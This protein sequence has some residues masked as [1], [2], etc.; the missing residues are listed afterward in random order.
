MTD[1]PDNEQLLLWWRQT[2]AGDTMAFECIHR[3]LFAALYN[4]ARKLLD[5]DALARDALQDLFIKIWTKRQAIGQLE[6]VKSYFF[7]A[8][9]RQVWNQQRNTRLRQMKINMLE[10]ALLF[11]PEE[12]VVEAQNQDSLRH[13]LLD[14]LNSLPSR[15]REVIYLRYF[16][17][18]DYQRIAEIMGINHQSALNLSQKALSKLR[19]AKLLSFFFLVF[20][21]C[22]K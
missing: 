9:R 7:T 1:A 16:E 19:A 8:L 4:Y 21:L 11:T 5:D 22:Q 6:K 10:P 12:I 15:Q 13:K 14:L 2:L 17:E 20:S 18:L 3:S